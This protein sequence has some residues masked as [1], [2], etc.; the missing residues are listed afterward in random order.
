MSCARLAVVTWP[1][2]LALALLTGGCA[3]PVAITIGSYGADGASLAESGKTIGDHFI[4]MVTKKDCALWRK[5]RNED[6]CRPRNSD[7]D[8]YHVN[9]DEPFRQQGEAGVEYG[10][11][12]RATAGAPATSWEAAAYKP[13]ATPSA[14]RVSAVGV[15]ARPKSILDRNAAQAAVQADGYKRVSILGKESNGA[16]S[17]K[18]YRGATEVLLSVDP[19]GRV[20]M[21]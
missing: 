15:E 8:P 21:R 4:S 1:F 9:Y 5:L 6:I 16:W 12:P 3:A 2:V 18:A 7:H 17:A 20:S 19:T 11:P 13:A 10:L 14:N